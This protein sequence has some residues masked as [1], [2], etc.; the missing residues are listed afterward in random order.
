MNKSTLIKGLFS[1]S[2]SMILIPLVLTFIISGF[3]AP[4]DFSINDMNTNYQNSA[5]L[6]FHGSILDITGC[7]SCHTQPLTGDC[8]ACHPSPSTVINEEVNFPHHDYTPGG[9]LDDCSDSICH[10]AE[11]D[12][13]YVV[14]LDANHDYC[15]LCHDDNQCGKCH[16]PGP[17]SYGS[18][19]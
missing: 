4:P 15:F 6:L 2:I 14:V 11:D 19:G 5:V 17:P 3:S 13:R 12:I 1:I 9:P 16:I 7:A 18:E 10:D 8:I